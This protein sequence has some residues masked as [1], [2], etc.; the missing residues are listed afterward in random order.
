[1]QV[2]AK[3]IIG[4]TFAY[5]GVAVL[6]HYCT[7]PWIQKAI[8][9]N[10]FNPVKYIT[11]ILPLNKWPFSSWQVHFHCLL[12]ASLVLSRHKSNF[13]LSSTLWSFCSHSA[14]KRGQDSEILGRLICNDFLYRLLNRTKYWRWSMTL[15]KPSWGASW[16][17]WI[18]SIADLHTK[19]LSL[20]LS[21]GEETP[22]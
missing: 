14:D 1:M 20:L 2:F 19:Q 18:S 15:P 17:Y 5:I 6:I 8:Q 3:C 21:N 22:T 12:K 11:G 7:V 16:I 9:R 10:N 4:A 13:F